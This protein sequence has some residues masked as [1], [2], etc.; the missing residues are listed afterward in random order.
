MLKFEIYRLLPMGCTVIVNSISFL[1]LDEL[2]YFIITVTHEK[3]L[4]L[5]C[6]PLK[7]MTFC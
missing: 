6:S 2:L 3:L 7:A 1:S 4:L 5:N